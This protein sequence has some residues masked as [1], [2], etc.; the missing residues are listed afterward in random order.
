MSSYIENLIKQGENGHL[1]FKFE[2]SDS[3]KIARTFSAFSNG[4]GG[5]LLIGV[6]DN[7]R[8]AGVR[9]EEEYYMAESAARLYCRPEIHFVAEKWMIEG[10][11]VLEI[12]IPEENRKPVEVKE[13]DQ[14]WKAYIR[15][16]DQNVQANS[17]QLKVWKQKLMPAGIYIHFSKAEKELLSFLSENESISLSKFSK[18]ALLR[19]FEAED[20]LANLIVSGVIQMDITA[21]S[22]QYR[23][24]LR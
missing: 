7:G 23:L 1:D 22:V 10:K 16:H 21:H 13:E 3:R 24:R 12:R 14:C 15:I 18:I 11:T 4:S 17:V 9:S 2:I 5:I 20:I 19:H 6:K 8:I